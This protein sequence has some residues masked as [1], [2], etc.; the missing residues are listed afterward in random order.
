M[1]GGGFHPG[2]N[3]TLVQLKGYTMKRITTELVRQCFN[4]TLVQLKAWVRGQIIESN[5]AEFQYHTGPIKREDKA[6]NLGVA[7]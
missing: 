4:T 6:D 3:T 7:T 1:L 2:F 5:E